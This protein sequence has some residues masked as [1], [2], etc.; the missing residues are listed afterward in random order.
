MVKRKKDGRSGLQIATELNELDVPTPKGKKW[1]DGTVWAVVYSR[2]AW[3]FWNTN[4]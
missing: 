4:D 2:Q 1:S 3:K